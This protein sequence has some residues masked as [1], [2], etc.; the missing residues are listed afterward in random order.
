MSIHLGT[1]HRAMAFLLAGLP[2]LL[3]G[4]ATA[5]GQEVKKPLYERLGGVYAIATVVDDFIERLLVNDVLNANP[6][7]NAARTAVP[8]AGL[9]YRVTEL[10]C[11]AT[12]GPCRYSGRSM[13]DSHQH[14]NITPAEWQAMAAEFKGTLDRFKVP[15]AEQSELFAIVEGVKPQIVMA[16]KP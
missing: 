6:R 13:K 8:K 10:V 9:K 4:P 2:L 5:A 1:R 14:L 11:Q 12:G 3:G 15:A 7:I 16:G